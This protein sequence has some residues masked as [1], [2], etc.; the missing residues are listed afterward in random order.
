[1]HGPITL[2]CLNRETPTS[3]H[4]RLR[5]IPLLYEIHEMLPPLHRF[6]QHLSHPC[7]A[8]TPPRWPTERPAPR[9][10]TPVRHGALGLKPVGGP[11]LLT[12]LLTNMKRVFTEAATPRPL[13]RASAPGPL[14]SPRSRPAG[15]AQRGTPFLGSSL[16]ACPGQ[17][18]SPGASLTI[19]TQ[20]CIRKKLTAGLTRSWMRARAAA[21]SSALMFP[22]RLGR[23]ATRTCFRTRATHQSRPR[24]PN[25]PISGRATPPR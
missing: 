10:V 23:P 2:Q 17:M 13:W 7:D 5:C 15:S 1:M 18:R 14:S 19:S 8:R 4:H 11:R 24:P 20:V 22:G 12:D 21:R 25:Q 9:G 3:L 6:P 16:P